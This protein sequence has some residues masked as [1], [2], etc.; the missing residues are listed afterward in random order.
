MLDVVQLH[1][2]KPPDGERWLA[3]IDQREDAHA[4]DLPQWRTLFGELYGIENYSY[5]CLDGERCLGALSLYRINSPFMGKML[6]SCPFF[7]YGGFYWET[8][9][10]RDAL[11]KRAT[12]CARELGV[13]FVELRLRS[14][15][16]G[17]F[18]CNDGFR[19]FVLEFGETTE[20]TWS[21][22]LASNVR[23]NIRKAREQ[24]LQFRVTSDHKATFGLLSRTLRAHGTPFHGRRF[25]ELL[26]KHLA[27]HVGYSEVRHAERLVA[28]GVVVRFKDTIITPYIGSLHDAR[29]LRPNYH[30]Y[31]ELV[32]HFAPLGVTRF[33]MGRSPVGSTHARFKTKWGCD[34][35]P[36]F[37][38]H[39]LTRE[40][41][42]YRS[43]SEPSAMEQL[44][45]RVWKKMPLALTTT[46][47]PRLFRYIP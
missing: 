18:G 15:L 35:L 41:A 13:D 40:G 8:D 45:T 16:G 28:A 29:A 34:E 46:L 7:G 33:D 37:Y 5:L 47:G 43:V 30:Q 32:E 2:G 44:A 21:K 42:R 20:E 10:A 23:Q 19:E 36:V 38:N 22:R 31:W 4:A 17:E 6:V 25:F 1:F 14:E 11:I 26:D 27:D 39:Q 3:Y 9:E 12:D 24:D